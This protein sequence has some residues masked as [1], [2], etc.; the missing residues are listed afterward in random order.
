MCWWPMPPDALD[1][2]CAP[3]QARDHKCLGYTLSGLGSFNPA[4]ASVENPRHAEI[5]AADVSPVRVAEFQAGLQPVA[6]CDRV[7]GRGPRGTQSRSRARG[8]KC[9]WVDRRVT[10]MNEVDRKRARQAAPSQ[11]RRPRNLQPRRH[12]DEENNERRR[13]AP[14]LP[15]AGQQSQGD[16]WATGT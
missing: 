15:E 16:I 14:L 12:D 11:Q 4:C 5:L 10:T 3:I 6:P 8:A 13:A 1:F 2:C 7:A 9:T